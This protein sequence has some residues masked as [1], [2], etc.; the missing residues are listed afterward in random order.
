MV[1]NHR[2]H[3]NDHPR[4]RREPAIEALGTCVD[5]PTLE[6]AVAEP[7]SIAVVLASIAAEVPDGEWDRLPAD[8]SSRFHRHMYGK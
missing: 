2:A 5:T 3:M 4:H 8:L 6:A 7:P 1:S